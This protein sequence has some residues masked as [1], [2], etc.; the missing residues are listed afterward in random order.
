MKCLI[1]FCRQDKKNIIN[2]LSA[3]LAQRMVKVNANDADIEKQFDLSLLCLLQ[4]ICPRIYVNCYT[5]IIFHFFQKMLNELK[6]CYSHTIFVLKFEQ[7]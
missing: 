4:Q 7:K 3:E 1:L 2:L 6:S 5:D